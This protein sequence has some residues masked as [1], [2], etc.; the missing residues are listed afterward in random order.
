MVAV[1]LAWRP[2]RVTVAVLAL[3]T[4]LGAWLLSPPWW[5]RL[6]QDSV[7]F[8]SAATLAADGGNPYD[9]QALRAQE[10]QVHD[11]QPAAARGAFS[12]LPLR[13]SPR[14]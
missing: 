2:G 7:V 5:N 11:Q 6:G 14:S 12:P 10:Q 1:G 4:I 3:A 8:Y 13:L 9:F